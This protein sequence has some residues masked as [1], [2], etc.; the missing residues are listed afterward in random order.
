MLKVANIIEDG[1]IAGPQVRM[2][3]VAFALAEDV[4]CRLIFPRDNSG[5]LQERCAALGISFQ[6]MPLTR[7]TKDPR[8]L[9]RYTLF[10]FWEIFLLVRLFRQEAYD[11]VHVSGG[12]WQYKGL[13]AARLCR[14]PAIWHLND[15]NMPRMIRT[16]FRGL[17]RFAQGFI[18]ASNK[19]HNYYSALIPAGTT[20]AV[21]PAPVDLERF[22]K[23]NVVDLGDEDRDLVEKLDQKIVVGT[24]SNI[25]PVKDLGTF[26]DMAAQCSGV[27]DDLA[28]VV[29]GPVYRN[30]SNYFEQLQ[31]RVRQVGLKNFYF[32]GG[33]KDVRS[34][35][36]RFD[37]YVC[38]SMAESSP[39]SVWEAMAMNKPVVSTDVG[40]V[41]CH[42]KN[43]VNGA[44]C[45]V[46]DAKCLAEAITMLS[47]DSEKCE[48]MGAVARQEACTSFALKDVAIRTRDFY[49]RVYDKHTRVR[50]TVS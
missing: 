33:R 3:N 16:I 2:V 21:V 39:I 5:M 35:L 30:Q 27:R 50:T 23:E 17:S 42:V 38:T 25:S 4:D 15:T 40:D 24:V 14:I 47:A 41:P 22:K 46:G 43:A 7:L 19:S 10:T 9:L 20:Q 6:T 36:S 34:L 26:I 32:A 12:S 8:I 11:L 44:I 49:F 28:F 1:R 31:A 13:I 37:I 48:L 29:I 45:E 18:F